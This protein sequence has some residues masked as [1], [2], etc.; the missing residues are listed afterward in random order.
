[1]STQNQN[2]NKNIGLVFLLNT[3]FAIIE[4]IGGILTGSILIISDAIH[5]FADSLSLGVSW[6]LQKKSKHKADYT[7]TFG[8]KRFSLLGALLNAV[9]LITGSLFVLYESGKRLFN[10]VTP[11]PQ[12]MLWL[13]I[14]GIVVNTYGA[15]RLKKGESGLNQ[16]VLSWHLLED[17][18]GWIAV[19][20]V[21]II[22]MY[23]DIP[24][25]DPLL[26]IGITF[27]ILF[28]VTK[29]LKKTLMIL[30]DSVPKEVNMDELNKNLLDLN[31]V[32]SYHHLHFWSIDD[33]SVAFSVHL[34]IED[35][36]SKETIIELKNKVRDLIKD[37]N[38]S[39]FTVQFDFIEEN[40]D[41]DFKK[42]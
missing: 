7:F 3:I 30:L 12:G 6:Y 5:D 35:N 26:S 17:V 42:A 34:V 36:S 40:C 31:K 33:K 15:Y 9:V 16:K 23:K 32:K 20:I 22:L 11:D 37:Y 8:Y 39:H 24:I 18:L 27:F 38:I 10:P 14:L 29:N 41:Q 4:V 19:L 21:S 1:M 25:L 2:T 13:A 28:H